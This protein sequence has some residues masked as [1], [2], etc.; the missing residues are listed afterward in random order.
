[1]STI[2]PALRTKRA[3]L[4]IPE[5]EARIAENI[6]PM[7]Q[8]MLD[9]ALGIHVQ[10]SKLIEGEVQTR[11]YQQPP[12][13]KALA[14]LIENV[15]GKVPQRVEMTGDGG[16]PIKIIPWMTIDEARRMSLL[17]TDEEDTVVDAEYHGVT[18]TATAT[19]TATST[20]TTTATATV[21][22]GLNGA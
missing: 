13:Y 7:L 15:I 21:E 14:F 19:P 11:V 17:D 16:G 6:E 22:A 5:V 2:L 1:M 10:V 8:A 20:V 18:T 3:L 9:L 4:K 12:D